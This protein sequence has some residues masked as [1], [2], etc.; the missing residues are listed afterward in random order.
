[1]V[2]GIYGSGGMGRE[3]LDTAQLINRWDEIIFIDDTVETDIYKGI[4]RM[5]YIDFKKLFVPAEAE[6]IIALG[7]PDYKIKLS[8]KLKEDGY[9]L[10]NI[11]HP[12]AVL[13]VSAKLGL[14]VNIRAGAVLSTDVIIGD[15]V[16]IMEH[17]YVGHDSVIGNDT[18]VSSNVSIGGHVHIGSGTFIGAN[19]SLREDISIGDG[20]IIGMG[21]TVVADI[22]DEMVY[23][24][25]IE[26]VLTPKDGRKVFK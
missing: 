22:L 19:A 24:N 18:Q 5:P 7:E 16:T 11:I 13:A 4:R 8:Q 3:T 9:R 14:G 26:A 12:D 1:M 21:S 17:V 23:Y 10:T 2:L 15:N 25:K 6:L 20:S